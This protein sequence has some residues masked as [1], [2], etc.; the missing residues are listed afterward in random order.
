MRSKLLRGGEDGGERIWALVFDIGDPV[1][2]T[3]RSFAEAHDLRGAHFSGIGAL[4]EVTLRYFSWEEKKYQDIPVRAQVEV[5]TLTGNVARASG[6]V[7]LHAHLVVGCSDGSA[8]GGHLKEGLVRP[9]L[10]VILTEEPTPLHR[11]TDE[12]TG[13]ALLQP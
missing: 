3:L 11:I 13:L 4:S 6:K 9:T 5:L 8:R 1:V 10:E 2:E 12:E 7:K